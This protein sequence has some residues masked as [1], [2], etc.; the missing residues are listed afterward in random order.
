MGLLD[1]L[2]IGTL[3]VMAAWPWVASRF[4]AFVATRPAASAAK[5]ADGSPIE[6]WRQAW[7][8]TLISLIDD[9]EGG[10]GHFADEKSALKLAKE[11]LWEVIGGDGPTP[12]KAK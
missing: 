5:P 11:L 3:A 4:A 9:I 6:E 8:S 7:S 12:S 1:W 10:E 2:V